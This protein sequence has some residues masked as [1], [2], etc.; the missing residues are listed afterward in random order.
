MFSLVPNN[1]D[2][3]KLWQDSKVDPRPTKRVRRPRI[4]R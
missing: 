3:Y 1:F 2:D 4:R